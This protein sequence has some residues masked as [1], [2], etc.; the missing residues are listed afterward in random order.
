MCIRDSLLLAGQIQARD[1]VAF[2]IG[3]RVMLAFSDQDN[4]NVGAFGGLHGFGK[5]AL[6]TARNFAAARLGDF[7]L[8]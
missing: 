4:G 5:P 3:V 8:G 7:G 1:I 6:V 2:A